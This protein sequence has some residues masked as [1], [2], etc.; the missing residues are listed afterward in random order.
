MKLTADETKFLA[1]IVT[2]DSRRVLFGLFERMLREQDASNRAV[3]APAVFRGQGRSQL[4]ADI[5]ATLDG[6]VAAAR[7]L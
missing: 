6:V 1:N 4:L 5:V 7:S 2:A 3:D